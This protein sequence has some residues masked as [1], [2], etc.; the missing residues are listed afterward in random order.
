MNG[1]E[2]SYKIDCN[3]L[4]IGGGLTSLI[5]AIEATKIVDNVILV[6]KRKV[7][8]SGN[9]IVSGAAFSAFVPSPG[10]PDSVEQHFIDIMKAGENI[11]DPVLARILAENA[12]RAMLTLEQ[13]GVKFL[14]NDGSYVRRTPPGHSWPRSIPT[15]LE[16]FAH[17]TRGLSITTPLLEVAKKRGVKMFTDMPVYKILVKEGTVCG[18]SVFDTFSGKQTVIS[19]KAVILSAGGGGCLYQHTNNTAD[20]TGDAFAL[21]IEAGASL[22]D[23]EFI[24]FYPTRSISPIHTNIS[25]P[26]FGEGAVLRNCHGEKFMAK[27]HKDGDMATRDVMSRAIYDEVQA[28]RDVSG[29]VYIDLSPVS[30]KSMELRFPTILKMLNAHGINPFEQWL[31]VSPAAHFIIGGI[32]IN[33]CCQTSITGLFAAGESAGGVHGANRLAGNALTET[34]VFGIKAGSEAAAYARRT[35]KIPEICFN[36]TDIP[37][38]KSGSIRVAELKT[39]LRQSLW[40][41]AGIVRSYTG[42]IKGQTELQQCQEGLSKCQV[43]N[44]ADQAAYLELSR[45]VQV[46]QLIITASLYRH[47]SRGAHFRSDYPDQDNTKW[48]GNSFVEKV[49][50]KVQ[51]KFIIRNP[52]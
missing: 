13:F 34:V 26:L 11:N 14:K 47:E 32:A 52:E 31:V 37:L 16:K 19:A 7:G 30:K 4:I 28:G 15:V 29:G 51:I 8:R 40:N 2:I 27:Y 20:M 36:K 3:V 17:S 5:A 42:L 12:E 41:F 38:K 45:M 46:G 43:E 9:T 49:G 10:N 48:L 1:S 39:H 50:E 44:S 35:K 6:C 21:A 23:M 25:S 24:Q 33:S 22:R 18:A